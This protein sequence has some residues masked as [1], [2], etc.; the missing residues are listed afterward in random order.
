MERRQ[1]NSI[2]A[3]YCCPQKALGIR[4]FFSL[5]K[6]KTDKCQERCYSKGRLSPACHHHWNRKK[7]EMTLSPC[8]SL[9]S[10]IILKEP[11]KITAVHTSHILG[12]TTSGWDWAFADSQV[13]LSSPW[14]R[15][16][17][18]TG[19]GSSHTITE[20]SPRSSCATVVP[21]VWN[22]PPPGIHSAVGFRCLPHVLVAERPSLT[23]LHHARSPSSPPFFFIALAVTHS[24]TVFPHQT[25]ASGEVQKSRGFVSQN[26][27]A[28]DVNTRY[29]F[30][31]LMNPLSWPGGPLHVFIT[32]C[33]VSGWSSGGVWWSHWGS[34]KTLPSHRDGSRHGCWPTTPPWVHRMPQTSSTQ[35]QW[36][37]LQ[38]PQAT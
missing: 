7:K 23:T 6:R 32:S 14:G 12:S 4:N 25:I 2:P 11:P 33:P 5:L 36:K 22:I 38:R 20:G 15:L 1:H 30:S 24:L 13:W 28:P 3:K 26:I 37:S 29:L 10:K 27:L 16:L 35:P 21:S 34:L 8:D 19:L 18:Q 17:S 9:P 31:K